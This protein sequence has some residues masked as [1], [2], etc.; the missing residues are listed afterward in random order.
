[1]PASNPYTAIDEMIADNFREDASLLAVCPLAHMQFYDRQ[2]DVRGDIDQSPDLGNR[3]WIFP[4]PD[5]DD[6]NWSSGCIR[7]VLKYLVGFGTGKMRMEDNRI[8]KWLVMRGFARL[9]RLENAAGDP[10]VPGA[11]PF[12]LESITPGRTNPEREPMYDPEEW[13]DERELTVVCHADRTLM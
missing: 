4:L 5:E 11:D 1:M 2:Q 9:H 10:L 13:M 7:I 12:L 6:W 3:L 8:L